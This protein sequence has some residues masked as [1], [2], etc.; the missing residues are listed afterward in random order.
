MKVCINT[1]LWFW[2]DDIWKSLCSGSV[3][4]L[5]LKLIL[6]FEVLASRYLKA[7]LN[8]ISDQSTWRLNSCLTTLPLSFCKLHRLE[9]WDPTNAQRSVLLGREGFRPPSS[10]VQ[11]LHDLP[12]KGIWR[13]RGLS[14]QAPPSLVPSEAEVDLLGIKTDFLGALKQWCT[15]STYWSPLHSSRIYSSQSHKLATSELSRGHVRTQ[16]T[17]P[18]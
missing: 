16:I 14:T 5:H 8:I 10:A 3:W 2:V 18:T 17:V 1:S 15:T 6:G 7:T 11:V 4:E 9:F 13:R 12:R